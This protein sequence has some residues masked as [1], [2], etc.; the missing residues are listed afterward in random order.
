MRRLWLKSGSVCA[1]LAIA[2]A[3]QAEE[4]KQEQTKSPASAPAQAKPAQ[5]EET[6]PDEEFLE[7]LG[8]V[9]SEEEAWTDYLAAND[10]KQKASASEKAKQTKVDDNEK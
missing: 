3:V 10:V 5:S 2:G 1:L 8:T 6:L 7:F 4:Q 9:G